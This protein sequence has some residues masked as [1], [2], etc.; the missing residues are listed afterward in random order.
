MDVDEIEDMLFGLDASH[1]DLGAALSDNSDDDVL[2]NLD[3][4]EEILWDQTDESL[5]MAVTTGRQYGQQIGTR[6]NEPRQL[7]KQQPT[8]SAVRPMRDG[9]LR[10]YLSNLLY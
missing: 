10:Y 5:P 2:E 8:Q 7:G 1:G 9:Y 3:D 4:D 6:T